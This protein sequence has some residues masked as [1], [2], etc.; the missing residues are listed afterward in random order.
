M[1]VTENGTRISEARKAVGYALDMPPGE[2]TGYVVVGMTADGRVE[3]VSNAATVVMAMHV[4][5]DAISVLAEEFPEG[6][7]WP[8]DS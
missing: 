4:L 1:A 6:G 3:V 2:I 7:P 5:A 8:A